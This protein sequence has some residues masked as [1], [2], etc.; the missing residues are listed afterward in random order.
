M[1][2]AQ[3]KQV[4]NEVDYWSNQL[5]TLRKHRET[6][7]SDVKKK[8][9]EALKKIRRIAELEQRIAASAHDRKLAQSIVSL[10]EASATQ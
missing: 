4:A 8:Q 5:K 10:L 7:S 6:L 1:S 3:A 9:G 2:R